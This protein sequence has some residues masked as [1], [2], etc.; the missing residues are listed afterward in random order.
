[1]T[2]VE[3]GEG[4]KHEVCERLRKG[5]QAWLSSCRLEYSKAVAAKGLLLY[6]DREV[7]KVVR[8][9]QP[10]ELVLHRELERCSPL[11]VRRTG[12]FSI[13][14]AMPTL[15]PKL[16]STVRDDLADLVSNHQFTCN[17]DLVGVLGQPIEQM[18]ASQFGGDDLGSSPVESTLL[19]RMLEYY[20]RMVPSLDVDD[21]ILLE[22]LPKELVQFVADPQWRLVASLPFAGVV[23]PVEP[24]TSDGISLVRLTAAERGRVA[25]ATAGDPR[26]LGDDARFRTVCDGSSANVYADCGLVVRA[27][28]PKPAPP[29]RNLRAERA[30][31]AVQLLGAPT[32]GL[33]AWSFGLEPE[34]IGII[35]IEPPA[36]FASTRP[37]DPIPSSSELVCDIARVEHALAV[38]ADSRTRLAVRR[39]ALGT[40]RLDPADALIDFTVA[41]ECALLPGK[42]TSELSLR[43]QLNGSRLLAE[44]LEDRRQLMD[45]LR[46]VYDGRSRLV[47][48]GKGMDDTE[49]RRRSGLAQGLA[50][51]VLIMCVTKGWPTEEAF[52]SMY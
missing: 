4:Q 52:R 16:P 21:P 29:A 37:V 19:W 13:D 18:I 20:L 38:D 8:G 6:V 5:L 49:I 34:W 24:L 39:F 44:G 9:R 48:G 42:A 11:R 10:N 27:T 35:S 26:L 33:G 46:D 15:D 23:P 43:F 36:M 2:D 14:E 22:T 12:R 47:H 1:M 7:P 30:L 3:P 51:K 32:T 41:L 45:Q 31:A 50:R 40:A 17:D 28:S 25:A